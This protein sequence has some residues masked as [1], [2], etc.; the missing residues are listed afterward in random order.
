MIDR[1][2]GYELTGGFIQTLRQLVRE[3]RAGFPSL[4]RRLT[5]TASL[6][7]YQIQKTAIAKDSIS[8]GGEGKV[9]LQDGPDLSER[10][11]DTVKVRNKSG[12][13]VSEG[14][15]VV[16]SYPING[17]WV[18]LPSGVGSGG[19]SDGGGLPEASPGCGC[20]NC[21]PGMQSHACSECGCVNRRRGTSLPYVEPA[22]GTDEI[23]NELQTIEEVLYFEA[24][25][26]RSKE[27]NGPSCGDGPRDK[28]RFFVDYAAGAA[29]VERT[30]GE[31]CPEIKLR[32]CMTTSCTKKCLC[33]WR[34]TLS[35]NGFTNVYPP[36]QCD[37]CVSPIFRPRPQQ[38]EDIQLCGDDSCVLSLDFTSS[39]EIS[40]TGL[41]FPMAI[42]GGDQPLNKFSFDGTYR[43]DRN[44]V[45][46][47]VC[48]DVGD[49][50]CVHWGYDEGWVTLP[51]FL[52]PDEGA[53][54]YG[55]EWMI[56]ASIIASGDNYRIWAGVNLRG[57]IDHADGEWNSYE[58]S[59][60][61]LAWVSDE[62]TCDQLKEVME[63]GTITLPAYCE[64]ASQWCP[65]PGS[66]TFRFSGM[67]NKRADSSGHPGSTCGGTDCTD[68]MCRIRCHEQ[69]SPLGT[70]VKFW[71][72]DESNTCTGDCG[73]CGSSCSGFTD[74]VFGNASEYEVGFIGEKPCFDFLP[75]YDYVE[76]SASYAGG[77]GGCDCANGA[78][79]RMCLAGE[80]LYSGTVYVCDQAF[81]FSYYFDPEDGLYHLDG[82]PPGNESTSTSSNP[83]GPFYF[84][85]GVQP[86]CD[87]FKITISAGGG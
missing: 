42:G 39:L 41:A 26:W 72:V 29:W 48:C 65:N 71:V 49:A 19:G 55:Y 50:E 25:V 46:N 54:V 37:L 86:P 78:S 14:D 30:D 62:M 34:F 5:G 43:L 60:C 77:S 28:Y 9:V 67:V 40:G 31:Y 24:C 66:A 10:N 68:A 51:L 20:N 3:W 12:A 84:F 22:F 75:E 8:D 27:I 53:D 74:E 57:G 4:F 13:T 45:L 76:A 63:A 32:W 81:E 23:W 64:N 33:P 47:G 11:G 44:H 15:K 85:S 38:L 2:E 70:P 73:Y 83:A 35:S 79:Q 56:G 59:N 82:G 6:T 80:G 16:V 1:E 21:P 18:I 52:M 17:R 87:N 7:E 36:A 61:Y 58:S 69:L